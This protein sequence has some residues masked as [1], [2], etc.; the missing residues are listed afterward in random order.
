MHLPGLK[1]RIQT[2][3]RH[4]VDDLSSQRIRNRQVFADSSAL[5]ARAVEVEVDG[6][7]ALPALVALVVGGGGR[8]LELGAQLFLRRGWGE[9]GA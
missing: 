4:R 1:H 2:Q 6:V 5:G 9:G 7:E 3:P 8:G